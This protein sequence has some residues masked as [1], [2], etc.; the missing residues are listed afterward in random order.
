MKVFKHKDLAV[1][2][3]TQIL[4][5]KINLTNAKYLIEMLEGGIE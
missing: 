5:S 4:R 1:Y 3:K 2:E